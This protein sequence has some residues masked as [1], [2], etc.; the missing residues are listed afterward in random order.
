MRT[1]QATQTVAQ[2]GVEFCWQEGYGAFTVSPSQREAVR[3]YVMLQEEH[4]KV[5]SFQEG[6]IELLKR[7]GVTYDERYLW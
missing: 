7:S 3:E 5:R 1:Q 2:E 6:Y 4:H